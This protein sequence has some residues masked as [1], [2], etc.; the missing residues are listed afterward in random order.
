MF[1]SRLLLLLTSLFLFACATQHP[2]QDP[3]GKMF[4]SVEGSSLEQETIKMP[5]KFLG[6]PTLL[7]LGYVQDSQFDIDRWL[8]ALDFT[9]TKVNVYELPTIA[10]MA[11]RMFSGF[12]DD[13]MRKG[14]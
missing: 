12:I 10:G 8:I 3:T 5:E 7:L 11:P 6:E 2:N 14:I 1:P 4:P 9:E 13:G